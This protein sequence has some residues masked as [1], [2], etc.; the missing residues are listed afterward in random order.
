MR[1]LKRRL[2]QPVGRWLGLI[3][4][5]APKAEPK[6]LVDEVRS[7]PSAQIG[8]FL[9]MALTGDMVPGARREDS[10]RVLVGVLRERAHADAAQV[11]ELKEA[12]PHS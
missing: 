12:F 7:W 10:I 9:H 2:R 6:S 1:W 5:P 11:D 3:P 8:Q 4:P